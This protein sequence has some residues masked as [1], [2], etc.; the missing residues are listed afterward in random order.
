M[1][2]PGLTPEERIKCRHHMGYLQVGEAYTFVF[3][4]PAAVE[5]TFII[6]GS[7]NRLLVAALPLVRQILLILEGIEEQ[8][9]TDQEL[10]A[11]NRLGEIEVNQKEQ[12]QLTDK[13]DYWVAALSNALGVPRNPFDKR[14]G[15]GSG[16]NAPVMG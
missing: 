4:Q 11:V 9:V 2:T 13:Y 8:M 3:G 16:I 10:M 14:L 1:T 12:R 5:T 15:A 7:M 6:E